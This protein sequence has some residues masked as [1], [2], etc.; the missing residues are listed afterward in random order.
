MRRAVALA[1]VILGFGGFAATQ[2]L[3]TAGASGPHASVIT[4]D[5]I[6][7]PIAA[8]YLSRGLDKAAEDGSRLVIVLLDT[9]GGLLSSTRDMVG[10][11]LDSNLPVVV[12]VWPPGAQAASA[13]TFIT[14]AGHVAAMAPTT[15]IGAA[16]PVGSGGEDLPD[17]LKS[18]ATQDAAAF[19]RTIAEVRGRNADAL[20]ETVIG[21]ASYTASEALENNVIDLIARDID[22]LLARLN[23][24]SV[25]VGSGDVIMETDGLEVREIGRTPVERFLGFVA[26]PD[27][28]FLLLTVGGIGIVVEVLSPGLVGPG[29]IGV[30]AMALAFVAFGQLPVNWTGVGLILMAMALFFLEAQA[31]GTSIFGISGAVSFVL[32]AFLLF[33]G[34]GAPA[35]PTPSFRVSLW[36]IGV[37]SGAVFGFLILMVRSV[38]VGRRRGYASTTSPLI[39]Q[40]GMTTSPLDPRG[41]VQVASERW[42]AVSDS[43]EPIDEGEEVIVQEVEGLTLKVFK[44]P[45]GI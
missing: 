38:L 29:I 13:G 30:I 6:I 14:A 21:A 27:I 43:G 22:D 41:T 20:E 33:G 44:A 34:F 28:A 2:A 25:A 16:S 31:P 19:I 11:I 24:R 42:S 4:I 40:T 37:V 26:N 45:K 17:T 23:G 15:N 7:D 36:L 32:G 3:A 5:G 1:L 39:G 10:D 9:P 18:K 8:G 12:Y 35:I